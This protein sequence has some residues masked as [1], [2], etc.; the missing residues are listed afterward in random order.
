MK[1]MHISDLHI[2]KR[3]NEFN[4]IEDQKFILEQIIHIAQE[5]H[6]DGVLIAGDIYDKSQPSAEAVVLL[7]YFLT[8]LTANGMPV[9]IIS[10]NH[11]SP[12]RLGFGNKLLYKNK[13]YIAGVFNGSLESFELKDEYGLVHI[14]L[15]PFLKP[16]ML[17]PHYEQAVDTYDEAVRMVISSAYINTS[18]RNILLAHQFIVSGAKQP[19][20]SDSETISV[21]GL[22]QIDS[23][24]F[25][26]FD[27]VAL[28]HLHGPQKIGRD[29][30]RYCGS[31]LKYSFSEVHQ[32]KSVVM[33]ELKNKG[34]LSI[35]LIPLNPIRDMRKIK[36]P[37]ETLL[38]LGREEIEAANDYIHAT[39]TD[40]EELYDAI[41]QLREVY[42]NI[43]GI[44]F[45]S[46]KSQSSST[47]NNAFTYMSKKSPMD[48][49]SEFYQLQNNNELNLQQEKILE[50]ILQQSGGDIL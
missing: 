11:D 16:A 7:D 41:G 50:A 9:F 38:Q 23:S 46:N 34:E 37:I 21:G 24:A 10:G 25:D 3:V 1:L 22:D 15:L 48:L 36:G 18:E 33:L 47:I 12:E 27:Y 43:M 6:P 5:E 4:L 26:P 35:D 13:L 29:S 30:I 32:K 20:I 40:E 45:E 42:P 31:P 44:D 17:R 39:L 2:G 28:G 14:H 49:F 8:K 19:E